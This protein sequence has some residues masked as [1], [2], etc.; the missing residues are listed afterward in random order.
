MSKKR[1][2]MPI[3][4]FAGLD[5]HGRLHW[6]YGDERFDRRKKEYPIY[7]NKRDAYLDWDNVCEVKIT[8]VRKRKRT[9]TREK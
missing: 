4:A 3:R 6:V 9:T 5:E 1:V 8:K 7:A 2:K